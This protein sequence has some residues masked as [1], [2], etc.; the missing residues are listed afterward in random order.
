MRVWDYLIEL[1]IR[2]LLTD[3][4]MAYMCLLA[5]FQ[6]KPWHNPFPFNLSPT[7]VV[8]DELIAPPGN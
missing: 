1:N 8:R 7:R 4:G 5:L 2:T 3:E 6:T